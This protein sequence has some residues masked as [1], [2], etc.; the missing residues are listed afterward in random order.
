M[1]RYE[2]VVLS[3]SIITVERPAGTALPLAEVQAA[4]MGLGIEVA[5]LLLTEDW[6]LF[7]ILRGATKKSESS[8]GRVK[9]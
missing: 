5:T 8:P 6:D 3:L 7:S 9:S 2:Q 4:E 1:S